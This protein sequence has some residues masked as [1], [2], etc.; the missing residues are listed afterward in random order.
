ME[1]AR[2]VERAGKVASAGPVVPRRQP[3]G[4]V[5]AHVRLEELYDAA[6]PDDRAGH[7]ACFPSCTSDQNWQHRKGRQKNNAHAG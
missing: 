3:S 2:E 6:H 7:S 1:G 5:V 4:F